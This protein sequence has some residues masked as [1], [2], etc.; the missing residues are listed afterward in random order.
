MTSNLPESAEEESES[1]E[2]TE[3]VLEDEQTSTDPVEVEAKVLK[4]TSLVSESRVLQRCNGPL[5]YSPLNNIV[6]LAV[7]IT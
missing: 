1:T 2:N 6:L 7:S 3:H 4:T 5:L